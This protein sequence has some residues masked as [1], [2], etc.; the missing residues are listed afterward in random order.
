MNKAGV[1]STKEPTGL[2]RTDEKRPDGVTL[3]PWAIEQ[4]LT[5]DVTVSDTFASSHIAST[6]YLPGAAAEHA[7]TLKKQ[8]YAALSQTHEFVPL[9]IETSG[10]FN[11]EGWELVK[12]IGSRI[13]NA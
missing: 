10:A 1:Q 12:K 11:S 8:K 9:A 5:Y 4:C 6:S 3:I 13:S 7:A 2:L